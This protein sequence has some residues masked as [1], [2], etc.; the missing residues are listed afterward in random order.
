MDTPNVYIVTKSSKKCKK[1]SQNC[2]KK[3]VV[4]QKAN[5]IVDIL[6]P[7]LHLCEHFVIYLSNFLRL[8]DICF[9]FVA[10]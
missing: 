10:A 7:S 2:E 5:I 3:T 6:Q 4:V 9:T 1:T 8:Q